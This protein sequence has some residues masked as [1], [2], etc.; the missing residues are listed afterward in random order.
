[1]IKEKQSF[2]RI[3]FGMMIS[4][5]SMLKEA[6]SEKRWYLSVAVSA[7]AFALFFLQTG[8]DLYKTGQKGAAFAVAAAIAGAVYGAVIIPVIGAVSWLILKLAKTEKGIKWGISSFCLSYSGTLIYGIM[9]LIFSL[10]LGWKTAVAFGVAGVLWAI[11]P[12]IATVRSMAQGKS[13]LSILIATLAS[14]FILLSW[15]VFGYI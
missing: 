11:G 7:A 4:P 1:M 9:G 15:S 5:S 10:L 12:M 6:V 13:N 3:I 14:C 2:I 8:L